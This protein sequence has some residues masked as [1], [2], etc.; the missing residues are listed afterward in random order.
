MAG[1]HYREL[2]KLTRST[3][4]YAGAAMASGGSDRRHGQRRVHKPSTPRLK[5]RRGRTLQKARTA[6]SGSA[7]ERRA[8]PAFL[9]TRAADVPGRKR[10]GA[11]V[12]AWGERAIPPFSARRF[13]AWVSPRLPL[14]LAPSPAHRRRSAAA[15]RAGPGR[16]SPPACL[17]S[18]ATAW[19]PSSAGPPS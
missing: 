3:L 5:E 15:S 4:T 2:I 7:F 13:F 18:R 10:G 14:R 12:R 6:L 17:L 8:L 1:P 16:L 11:P 9:M 19:P